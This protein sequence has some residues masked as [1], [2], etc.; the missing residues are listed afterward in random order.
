[1]Q[2]GMGTLQENGRYAIRQIAADLQQAGFGGCQSPQLEPRVVNVVSSPPAYLDEF[3]GGAF[4]DGLDDQSSAT[5]FGGVSMVLNTDSI[6]IRG[7][8]RSNINYVAGPV[9]KSGGITVRGTAT[10]FA[11]N[12]YLLISDCSSATIFR[13]SA[14]STSGGNTQVTHTTGNLS[15][16]L[17]QPYGSDA[18]V[19]AF[20]VHTYFVGQTTRT[21]QAGQ[22]IN[23][24]YRFDGANAVEL[25]EGIDDM[26]IEYAIDTDGNGRIDAFGTA[27]DMAAGTFDWD[28]VQAVRIALLLNSVEGASSDVAPYTFFPAGTTPVS[29]S[30]GDYRLR[31]EFS[32]LISI[33]NAVF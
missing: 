14:V 23:A 19:V 9:L 11:A 25:I 20:A 27:A 13:A 32:S 18:Q 10:G 26:Q 30:A 16:D 2:N 8:L 33:R 3:A 5:T 29:P 1:M 28:E 4:F 17:A 22:A 24:L 15:G 21:N 31:Q 12:E 6:E 7:P